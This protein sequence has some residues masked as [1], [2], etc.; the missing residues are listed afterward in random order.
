MTT[1]AVAVSVGEG[2]EVVGVAV[3]LGE[4]EDV[5]GGV[6]AADGELLHPLSATTATSTVPINVV[7]LKRWRLIVGEF[8]TPY[9]GR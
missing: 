9:E 7:G 8:G 1:T 5:A 3:G 2:V 6:A 4:G